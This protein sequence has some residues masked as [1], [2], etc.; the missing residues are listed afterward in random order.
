ME[1]WSIIRSYFPQMNLS[2]GLDG[3]YFALDNIVGLY[4]WVVHRNMVPHFYHLTFYEQ[5]RRQLIIVK[6]L[7][8]KVYKQ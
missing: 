4:G 5:M 2:P 8:Y 3:D 7:L 1:L 6:F